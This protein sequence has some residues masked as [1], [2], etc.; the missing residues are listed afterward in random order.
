VLNQVAQFNKKV[1]PMRYACNFLTGVVTAVISLIVFIHMWVA[2]T[3]RNDN[4]QLDPYLNQMLDNMY[5]YS[6][7]SFMSILFFLFFGYYLFFATMQGNIKF[8]LRFFSLNFYPLVPG[9]TFVNA[10]MVNAFLMNIYMYSLTYWICDLF[11]FYL[12]GTQAAIFFQV[13]AK[14]QEFYGWAF[15]R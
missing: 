4:R 1:E 11:R 15:S 10:F 5:E 7:W 6:N 14:H 13:I 2:G 8:G 3:L 12:R 9:E